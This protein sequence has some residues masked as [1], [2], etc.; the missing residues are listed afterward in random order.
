MKKI[1]ATIALMSAP[2]AVNAQPVTIDF[3]ATI[4]DASGTFAGDT[5]TITGSYLLNYSNAQLSGGTVG[6]A[7][8][9]ESLSGGAYVFSTTSVFDAGQNIYGDGLPGAFSNQSLVQAI[10]GQGFVAGNQQQTDANDFTLSGIVITSAGT[11]WS[12]NGTPVPG[13]GDVATG[14]IEVVINGVQSL[15]DYNVTSLKVAPTATA[16]PEIDSASTASGLTLLLGTLVVLRG[17]RSVKL[18][19]AAA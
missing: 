1:L 6:S 15:L 16:A 12:V 10:P 4:A 17:R 7:P 19:N 14:G 18:G 5:G 9:W 8:G 11:P 2:I 3:Q 13:A